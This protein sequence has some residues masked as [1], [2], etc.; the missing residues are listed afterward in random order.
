MAG[1]RSGATST[2]C[3]STWRAVRCNTVTLSVAPD[4]KV[5]ELRVAA[6]RVVRK[7][8]AFQRRGMVEAEPR[9]AD[10][11]GGRS[12]G[13]DHDRAG[14][15]RA[16]QVPGGLST[17]RPAGGGLCAG[18]GL[19]RPD[20]HAGVPPRPAAGQRLADPRLADRRTRRGGMD[21]KGL[22]V[23]DDD[24]GGVYPGLR[25]VLVV[26]H[27]VLVFERHYHGAIPTTYF[28]LWSVTKS[29]TAALVGIALGEHT[30]GGLDQPIGRLLATHLPPRADPRL[31]RATLEQLLTMTAGLPADPTDGSPP[32]LVHAGDWVRFV[33]SQHPAATPGTRF[34]YSSDDSH[35]LSAII[36]DNSGQPTL[37]YAQAKLFA[38]LGIANDQPFQPLFA[39]PN[40]AAYQRAG[41]AWPTDPQGYHL[42]YAFLKLTARD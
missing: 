9:G 41:F 37:R 21:P 3:N 39:A 13:E 36:A 11:T 30:L 27:G 19:H 4:A 7:M 2:K 6:S 24:A 31:P 40:Q 25:S 16:G 22:A 17:R 35:L 14:G 1:R 34:A 28:N 23:I 12:K 18:G 42:G 5:A 29:V 33:L 20:R 26:R 8:A 10:N 32:S 15:M 38:P